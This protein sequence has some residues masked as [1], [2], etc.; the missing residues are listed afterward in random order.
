MLP[1][2][3]SANTPGIQITT[4]VSIGRHPNSGRNCRADQ[5]ARAVEMGLSVCAEN[6]EVVHAGDAQVQA[7]RE[8]AGMGLPALKVIEQEAGTD[9]VSA[10]SEYL[11]CEAPDIILTGVRAE[12]GLSSGMVP[13]LLAE[14][15]G[16]PLVCSITSIIKL[17]DQYAEVLQALPRGQRRAIQVKMPFIASVNGAAQEPRQSA[18][19]PAKRADIT[20]QN[21]GI[22]AADENR[23][24]WEIT[25]AKKRPKRLKIVKAKT[26]AD[27][28]KLATAKTTSSQG[29]VLIQE[30]PGEKA[31]AIYNVLTEEGVIR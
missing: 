27:R 19:G 5:D 7:L 16:L 28:F 25:A 17:T 1:N 30:S 22:H 6:L 2:I 15:L 13:F 3:N 11:S 4:L 8:Y 21:R 14:K 24:D 10:L 18:F 23:D 12:A 20:N 9:V 31:Q 29:Q 26:A